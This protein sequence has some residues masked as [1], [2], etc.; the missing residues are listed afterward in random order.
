MLARVAPILK[1]MLPFCGGDEFTVGVLWDY[2]S[3]PQPVRSAQ[4]AE[5]FASGLR[6]LM[7]WYA[8]P[9]TH[10]LLMTTE[11]PAGAAYTNQ[12]SYNERGWCEA[13]RRT[14]AISKCTA[15]AARPRPLNRPSLD[16]PCMKASTC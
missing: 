6:E 2:M 13:E 16:A 4:E 15:S 10:V 11:L 14:C 8:H 9:Y 5:R 3:L 7:T 12:R 1:R